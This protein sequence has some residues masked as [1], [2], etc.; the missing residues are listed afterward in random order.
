M[1]VTASIQ[2]FLHSGGKSASF[3]RNDVFE[4]GHKVF[5]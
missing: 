1:L 2:G 3:G 4:E 5:E